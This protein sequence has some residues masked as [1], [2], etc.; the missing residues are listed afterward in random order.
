MSLHLHCVDPGGQRATIG[1][2]VSGEETILSVIRPCKMEV[3]ANTTLD[4]IESPQ[5]V[6]SYLLKG[7]RRRLGVIVLQLVG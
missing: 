3:L 2:T 6:I 7:E 1:V 5:I 4:M